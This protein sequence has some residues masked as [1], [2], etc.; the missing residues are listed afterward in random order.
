MVAFQAPQPLLIGEARGAIQITL[1]LEQPEQQRHAWPRVELAMKEISVAGVQ[2]PFVT[3]THGDPAMPMRMAR[4]RNDQDI[5]V[6]TD[7]RANAAK[8][9]PI[10][11]ILAVEL[12]VGTM[13]PLTGQIAAAGRCQCSL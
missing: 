8:A 5:A 12:P 11:T 6:A 2:Q 1:A 13:P 3:P 7:R 10:L 9:E 4:Q